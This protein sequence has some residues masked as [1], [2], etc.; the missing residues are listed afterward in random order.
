MGK[1]LKKTGP[2]DRQIVYNLGV[3]GTIVMDLS[4]RI[5][6]LLPVGL[7]VAFLLFFGG[8]SCK[9]GAPDYTLT[10]VLA[11]GVTGTP[12]SGE[13]VYKE[14]SVVSFSY[15]GTNTAWSIETHLNDKIRY[16]SS[17]SIVMY[18][19]HYVLTA[20]VIDIR[21]AWTVTM[22]KTG[23]TT[24][25]FTFTLTLTGADVLS[26]AFTDSRGYNGTWT[27]SSGVLI[28]TYTD[29]VDYV[30]TGTVYSMTGT[31]AGD[32]TTGTFSATKVT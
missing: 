4:K 29:W 25:T 9:M 17:G 12:A 8:T 1:G 3:K 30:L 7:A 20:N 13:Y 5:S 23:E 22:I 26:G 18:G 11:D 32:S 24:V 19:D 27:A 2:S 10:V 6:Q 14:L 15:T 16:S 31:Y 28:L 21:G